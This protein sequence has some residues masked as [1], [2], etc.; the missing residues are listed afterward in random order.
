MLHRFRDDPAARVAALLSQRMLELQADSVGVEDALGPHHPGGLVL[1][2]GVALSGNDL[3]A[4]ALVDQRVSGVQ[5]PRAAERVPS[6]RALIRQ[7]GVDPSLILTLGIPPPELHADRVSIAGTTGTIGF[8]M[9]DRLGTDCYSTAGHV[10][11]ST[12]NDA[13]IDG[14]HIG[15][16][17]DVF[18]PE[19]GGAAGPDVAVIPAKSPMRKVPTGDYREG[20]PGDQIEILTPSGTKVD[21]I[22]GFLEW[23]RFPRTNV[24]SKN[25]YITELGVTSAGDSGAAALSGNDAIAHVIG[26]AGS[27]T[28]FLQDLGYQLDSLSARLMPPQDSR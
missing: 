5:G 6:V 22:M 4:V 15:T 10:A 27:A 17:S 24:R 16:T 3:S 12:G 26:A 13:Y 23:V 21:S 8:G 19:P 18:N 1:G 28:S 2:V 9:V 14:V 11:V 7:A 25:V 20:E